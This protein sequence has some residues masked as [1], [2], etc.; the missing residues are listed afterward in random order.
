MKEVHTKGLEKERIRLMESGELRVLWQVNEYLYDVE[1]WLLNAEGNRNKWKFINLEE[2]RALFAGTPILIAYI[3]KGAG[4]GDGH[5]F[6]LRRDPKTGKERPSFTAETA[7]RIVGSLSDD[8]RD[9]RLE[10]RDGVTWIVG[11]GTL[12]KFYAPE[13]VDKITADAAQGRAMSISIEAMIEKFH[14]EGDVEV[15]ERYTPLGTTILGDHVAPAV[16]EARV[17]ALGRGS[18]AE[19]KVRAASYRGNQS[20]KNWKEGGS[21]TMNKQAVARLASKFEGYRII[22]MSKDEKRVALA[23]QKGAIFS[24]T[25]GEDDQG[26]VILAKLKAV[27]LD[28]SVGAASGEEGLAVDV[29]EILD[30]VTNSVRDQAKTIE[31]LNKQLEEA[32]ATIE[33]MKQAEQKRRVDS[34]KKTLERTMAEIEA[35]EDGDVEE[36]KEQAKALSEKA[37]D[38]AAQED[39]EGAFCGD[40]QARKDLMALNGERCMKLAA[41]RKNAGKKEY[42]WNRLEQGED[43]DDGSIEALLHRMGIE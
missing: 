33:S 8:P 6:E 31:H 25:F 27:N 1:L 13:L 40:Q 35:S 32:N 20:K 36:L 37:E 10:E 18:F 34:V 11:R 2:H 9:I 7:E 4:I 26:E 5:N 30:H 14:M 39:A 43:Q 24:Y 17:V 15:Q 41:S 29:D 42:V 28:A 23:D 21:L 16:K 12:W 3:N 19:L 22:G 38:Y